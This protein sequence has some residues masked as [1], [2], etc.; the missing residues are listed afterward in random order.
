MVRWTG[1]IIPTEYQ[2]YYHLSCIEDM[3]S[4]YFSA[5][6]QQPNYRP[7]RLLSP[8][9]VVRPTYSNSVSNN[10]RNSITA[11]ILHYLAVNLY[12]EHNFP[13][14][15]IYGRVTIAPRSLFF[16]TRAIFLDS[17]TRDTVDRYGL[18][19]DEVEGKSLTQC[20][21]QAYRRYW[22]G[23]MDLKT[24]VRPCKKR[25]TQKEQ[26]KVHQKTKAM[27]SYAGRE[28]ETC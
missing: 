27:Q 5:E 6:R 20:L 11:Y 21:N 2:Q 24:W 17:L 15:P 10:I 1:D 12:Q 8:W 16:S 26:N 13:E 19:A 4:P 7:F 23:R 3:F 18:N 28:T 22:K 14:R 25:K 9:I